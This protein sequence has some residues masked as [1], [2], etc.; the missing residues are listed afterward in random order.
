MSADVKPVESV[1]LP[2]SMAAV[3]INSLY[4]PNIRYPYHH[5]H[6]QHHH[7]L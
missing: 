7:P 3:K 6:H 5:H 4:I 1:P 2:I